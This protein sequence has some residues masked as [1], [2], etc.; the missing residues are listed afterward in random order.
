MK[1]IFCVVA[2]IL[3]VLSVNIADGG[4]KRIHAKKFRKLLRKSGGNL[5]IYHHHY[6]GQVTI[7]RYVNGRI[8]KDNQPISDQ[9][10]TNEKI[11]EAPAPPPPDIVTPK[12]S[13]EVAPKPPSKA[14]EGTEKPSKKD[15]K[16]KPF[17]IL[18]GRK[19]AKGKPEKSEKQNKPGRQETKDS[20]SPFNLTG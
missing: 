15:V 1:R 14:T 17:S 13:Q 18:K 12:E 3:M 8:V 19:K 4:C 11:K 9:S 10:S 16:P 6:N 2:S 7:T 5:T 20:T